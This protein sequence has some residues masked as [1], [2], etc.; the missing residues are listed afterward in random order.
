MKN[1]MA[2]PKEYSG[3]K[4][5]FSIIPIVY[6]GNESWMHG[7]KN[8][9]SAIISA[10]ENL[11]YYD[12]QFEVEP[13]LF[14]IETQSEIVPGKIKEEDAVKI[15]EAKL[16]KHVS[17][18]KFPIFLGGDHSITI[19]STKAM[20]RIF[21]D[22]SFISI[23][24]HSDLRESWNGSRF[25]HACTTRRVLERHKCLIIGLRSQ[26]VD[27]KDFMKSNKNVSA[28]RKYDFS[29]KLLSEKLSNLSRNVYISI[30]A[31]AFDPSFIR[32][33]GTP[34]PGGFFWDKII[35]I[36]SE[37]FR[38]KNVIGADI[39]EFAPSEKPEGFN[40]EAFALAKL[41][42]KMMALKGISEKS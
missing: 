4:S 27:E 14:G 7:A 42:Y 11:E 10:S 24:A 36:L 35:G 33:T 17:A 28:I 6:E 21:S 9:P 32:N 13:F 38:K 37:I 30:D 23:D 29:K 8:G 20:E 12:E 1:F 3:K 34:E 41:C 40:A 16:K 39:V 18:A 19:A 15:I 25:N 5:K 22:F 31:D 2:I 26:D